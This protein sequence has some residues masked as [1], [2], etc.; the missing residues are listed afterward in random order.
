MRDTHSAA[1]IP[2]PRGRHSYGVMRAGRARRGERTVAV[3]LALAGVA[4]AAGCGGADDVG[5]ATAGVRVTVDSVGGVPHVLN[6]GAP[7]TWRLEPT[8]TITDADGERLVRVTGVVGDWKGGI[9]VADAGTLTIHR[10]DAEGSYLGRLGGRGNA[11]G[12]FR[13]MVGLAWVAGKLAS[14]DVANDRITLLPADG[15]G[16]AQGVRWQPG[17]GIRQLE[18]TRPGEAYAPTAAAFSASAPDG[19]HIRVLGSGVPDTLPPNGFS[20]PSLGWI[21][22]QGADG[23]HRFDV[24]FTAHPFVARAPEL[25]SV[26]GNTGSYRLALLDAA[27]DTLR[28]IEREQDTVAVSDEEW[29]RAEQEWAR[30]QQ[31]NAGAQC[32][33]TGI[34]RPEVRA[35]FRDLYWDDG[36]RIWLEAAAPGGFRLDVFDSTGVLVGELPAPERDRSVPISIRSGWVYWA[37]SDSTGTPTVHAARLVAP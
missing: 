8:V 28:V 29:A 7:T 16:E 31:E 27:G 2:A 21:T 15:E 20:I 32:D 23:V 12:Q 36:G 13:D 26:V 33:T 3:W 11:P 37:S 30:F 5:G 1:T 9:Y 19:G 25:R 6:A 17:P 24:P 22:C 18:Q 10:F 4:L 34:E 35:A 14:L